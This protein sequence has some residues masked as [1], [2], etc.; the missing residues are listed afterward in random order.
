MRKFLTSTLLVVATLGIFPAA[1]AVN[2]AQGNATIETLQVPLTPG[3]GNVNI[4]W[5]DTGLGRYASYVTPQDA[6]GSSYA[7][8]REL[9]WVRYVGTARAA[10]N[11][12]GGQRITGVCIWYTRNGA[13]K[14]YKGCSYASSNGRS[15][16][17]G[18]VTI[19]ETW[20]TIDPN[21]PKTI[22][23]IQTTRINPNIF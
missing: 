7:I 16:A 4:E 12:Y 11:I 19:V 9:A 3:A 18:L 14:S 22:F 20:D 2:N 10:G 15:W 8:S 6:W 17:A 5:S 1:H 21:A 13:M 23:N